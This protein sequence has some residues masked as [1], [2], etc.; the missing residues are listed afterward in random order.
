MLQLYYGW[1]VH[2]SIGKVYG[3]YNLDRPSPI[4]LHPT[5]AISQALASNNQIAD[6]SCFNK[7][8]RLTIHLSL[9]KAEA[10]H[11]YHTSRTR[12]RGIFHRR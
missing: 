10:K 3:R 1:S 11:E 8:E 4:A 6:R 7:T 9:T 12:W 5:D 2:K